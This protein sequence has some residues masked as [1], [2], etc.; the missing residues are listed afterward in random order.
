MNVF[1]D[2]SVWSLA[3]RRTTPPSIPQVQL[4]AKCLE[5]GDVVITTGIVLQELLQGFSG[6]KARDKIIQRFSHLPLITPELEDHIEAA[7]L[8]NRCRRKGI[9]VGTID[10]LIAQLCIR[11]ELPLMTTDEDFSHISRHTELELVDL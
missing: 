8:K 6:P 3:L 2:T 1:V 11:H 5:R 9:Q 10:A 4:L 7:D